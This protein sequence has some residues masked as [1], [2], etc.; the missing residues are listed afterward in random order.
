MD[1]SEMPLK[2]IW[3]KY[4]VYA[5]IKNISDSWSEVKKTNL[6]GCWKNIWPQHTSKNFNSFH[7]PIPD[8]TKDVKEL[9]KQL[10]L[11]ISEDDVPENLNLSL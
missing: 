1:D 9:G 11:D 8:L 3:K 6:K 4:N 2:V 10:H 5:V 7:E